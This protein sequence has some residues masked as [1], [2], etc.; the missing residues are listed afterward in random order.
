MAR[1][2]KLQSPNFIKQSKIFQSRRRTRKNMN[3]MT[4]QTSNQIL[5]PLT[6]N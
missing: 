1:E 4:K 3:F 6:N 5:A 2:R